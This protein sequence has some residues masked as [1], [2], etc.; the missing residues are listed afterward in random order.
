MRTRIKLA[1]ASLSVFA[2]TAF[3]VVPADTWWR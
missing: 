1:L 3:T 2:A